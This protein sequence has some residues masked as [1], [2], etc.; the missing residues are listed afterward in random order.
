MNKRITVELKNPN[1]LR[2]LKDLEIINII[3][4]IDNEVKKGKIKLSKK[5]RGVIS[6]ERALELNSELD[7][8]RNEWEHRDI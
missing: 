8:I 4:V 6:K 1:A 7:E 5:L 3:K 2:I